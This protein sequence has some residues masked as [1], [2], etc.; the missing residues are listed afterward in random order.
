MGP[1]MNLFNKTHLTIHVKER[2]DHIIGLREYWII[3]RVLH[4]AQNLL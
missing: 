3:T 1:T 4:L 2:D